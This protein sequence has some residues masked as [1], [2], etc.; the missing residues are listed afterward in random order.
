MIVLLGPQAVCGFSKKWLCLHKQ[1]LLET[2]R[3]MLEEHAVQTRVL[4]VLV[5][6]TQEFTGDLKKP[7]FLARP[8]A[9]N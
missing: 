9:R 7:I 8:E 2:Y 5:H 4:L 3:Q 6:A 1:G